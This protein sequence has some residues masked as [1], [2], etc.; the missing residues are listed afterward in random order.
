MTQLEHLWLGETQCT[1]AGLAHLKGMPSLQG[2]YLWDTQ[3]TDAGVK[4]LHDA[5]PKCKIHY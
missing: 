4:D 2:L 3:V 1:D 5:L